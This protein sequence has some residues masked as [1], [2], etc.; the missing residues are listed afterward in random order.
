MLRAGRG[1]RDQNSRMRL[2]LWWFVAIVSRSRAIHCRKPSRPL[3]TQRDLMEACAIVIVESSSLIN[4]LLDCA[5]VVAG[6][7]DGVLVW[8][9]VESTF[10]S[11]AGVGFP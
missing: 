6:L 10:L 1:S 11:V 4:I 3:T 8:S 5:V 9:R 2:W 7:V